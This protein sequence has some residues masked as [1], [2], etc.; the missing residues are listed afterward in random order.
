MRWTY[1]NN[2]FCKLESRFS[3]GS[4][5]VR[6]VPFPPVLGPMPASSASAETLVPTNVFGNAVPHRLAMG[7]PPPAP[8]ALGSAVAAPPRN[9]R[10]AAAHTRPM[11]S[12]DGMISLASL[13]T[14]KSSNAGRFQH[15]RQYAPAGIGGNT[16]RVSAS[17]AALLALA[18]ASRLEPSSPP[19]RPRTR[20]PIIGAVPECATGR[21]C[22]FPPQHFSPCPLALTVVRA[23]RFTCSYAQAIAAEADADGGHVG[24]SLWRPRVSLPRTRHHRHSRRPCQLALLVL[25]LTEAPRV[26]AVARGPEAVQLGENAA[27][28]GDTRSIAPALDRWPV[29]LP[30]ARSLASIVFSSTGRTQR[31]LHVLRFSR[32]W[33]CTTLSTWTCNGHGSVVPYTQGSPWGR[34]IRPHGR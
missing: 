1:R 11:G 33:T 5:P 26:R 8:V 4:T 30:V 24:A 2:L 22:A 3:C 18:P 27:A 28:G 21:S 17:D 34:C 32:T 7:L 23:A 16:M 25:T 14:L 10:H 20:D 29:G 13:R 15:S 6:Q 12:S 9:L 19:R 31:S